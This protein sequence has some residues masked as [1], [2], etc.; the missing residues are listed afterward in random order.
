MK[1]ID[2]PYRSVAIGAIFSLSL[3]FACSV[4][5]AV[6]DDTAGTHPTGNSSGGPGIGTDAGTSTDAPRTPDAPQGPDAPRNSDAPANP[7]APHNPDAPLYPDAPFV[8]D[9]PVFDAPVWSDVPIGTGTEYHVGPSQTYANVGDV[10]WFSLKGGDTVYIHYRNAPYRE[11]VLISTLGNASQWLRVLG[12]P[13]PNGELP[14]LSGDNATT[15]RNMHYR[16]QEPTGGSAIQWDGV[17]QIAPRADD[18]A[19]A[20]VPGYIEI[21]N[22][23]VQDAYPTYQF[24]AENGATANY[25]GFASC[26][27]ARSSQHIVI[28]NN[29][30]T[31]CGQGFYNWTGSGSHVWDG[32]E[33]ETVLQG[34]YFYNNGFTN[35]YTE[36]Q[37]YTEGNGVIIEFNRFGPQRSGALG[38]Q[39]KD[40]SAGTVIRY[41][42]IEQSPAG[43]N[44]DLVEPQEAFDAV[45]GSPAYKQAFVYGNIIVNKTTYDPD[46]IHW[47]EDHQVG[48]GRA[49]LQGGKLFFYNNTVVTVANQSDM[50]SFN[51][52]F[53]VTFGG[54]DCPSGSLPGII[55]VRNNI[56]AVL[57]RTGG[58]AIPAQIF[59]HCGLENFDFGNN[60]VS[61]G[62]GFRGAQISGQANFSSPAANN[63]GFVDI[64]NDDFHL[65]LGSS[66]I[67]IG[68]PLAPE[69]TSNSLG[70]DLTPNA[71]YVYH[72]GAE[73][74]ASSGSGSDVGAFAR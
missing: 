72:Q 59:G 54:F 62:F 23:Q 7:D 50:P 37:T 22:L 12:V 58:S 20:P 16:W 51:N 8:P 43:W 19:N 9:A 48:N 63:P 2:L 15:S 52:L 29:V 28:R 39:L 4:D 10:P 44:M 64:A 17:I 65:V 24:T 36:H 30:M 45:G 31:N 74:R 11:K 42:F 6:V 34:N 3:S 5:D 40:R 69:V 18:S 21:A 56:F 46:Y 35:S 26:I 55:D 33:A 61:P 66:A 67:G 71:Q 25:E 70:L 73:S 60:W 47:N 41:N 49:T 13:G 68:G 32:L 38:S 1:T 57:P 53:N 27:Y 14:I